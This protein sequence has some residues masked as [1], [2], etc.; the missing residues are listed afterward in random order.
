MS[1]KEVKNNNITIMMSKK[2]LIYLE[3]LS[4]KNK[5]IESCAILVGNLN[6]YQ[7]KV[8]DIIQMENSN[9]SEIR[10]SINEE[11]LYALYKKI[12]SMNLS[13]IGIFHSHPSMP[14]PS[15]TD[16][17][18]MQINPVPWVITSTIDGDTKCFVFDE[19][20]GI[21]KIDLLVMD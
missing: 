14:F 3:K 4:Q 18:Y 16:I 17:Q 6:N 15:K 9:K 7:Y 1:H 19:K 12:E 2:Q 5:P 21:L 10:F 13:I 11:K 8:F 20:E